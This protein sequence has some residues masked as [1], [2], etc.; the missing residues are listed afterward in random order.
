[1]G[2]TWVQLQEK[3]SDLVL[4]GLRSADGNL[5]YAA[6]MIVNI[7]KLEKQY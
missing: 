7:R 6:F 1:M 4:Q 2:E 5:R 3:K